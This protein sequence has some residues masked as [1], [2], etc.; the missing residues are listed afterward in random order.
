[1]EGE[2]VGGGKDGHG[3]SESSECLP[4]ECLP[5][6]KHKGREMPRGRGSGRW[7]DYKRSNLSKDAGSWYSICGIG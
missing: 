4:S 3:E 1:M 5:V 2:L 7:V 6:K